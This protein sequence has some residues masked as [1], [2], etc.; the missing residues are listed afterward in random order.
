MACIARRRLLQAGGMVGGPPTR[1]V[2]GSQH[3]KRLR[4]IEGPVIADRRSLNGFCQS[5]FAS[6]TPPADTVTFHQRPS[7]RLPMFA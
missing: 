3:A 6:L 1:E 2:H 5:G 4:L 7:G